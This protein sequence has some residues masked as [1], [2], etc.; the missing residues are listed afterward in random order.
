[1]LQTFTE[2]HTEASYEI[3]ISIST[4]AGSKARQSPQSWEAAKFLYG[5]LSEKELQGYALCPRTK[6]PEQISQ[7]A[8]SLRCFHRE[9]GFHAASA[10]DPQTHEGWHSTSLEWI[11]MSSA[12]ESCAT[13]RKESIGPIAAPAK[14]VKS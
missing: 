11:Y 12:L 6:D 13:S 7:R 5:S 4:M 3:P 2:S 1:L 14:G 10:V 8:K 9:I